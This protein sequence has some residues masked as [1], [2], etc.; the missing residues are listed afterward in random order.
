MRLGGRNDLTIAQRETVQTIWANWS[1]RRA[2]AAMD[3]GNLRRAVEILEAA[4]QAFPDN[5]A[6][7]KAVAGGYARVGRAKESLALYRAIPMQDASSGDFQGAIGAALQA[8]D[9]NQA[10]LWLRQALDRFATDP[11]ILA[12]AA[13]YEQARLSTASPTTP[14][15][16]TRTRSRIAP[17]QPQTCITCLTPTTSPSLRQRSSRRSPPTDPIP[18]TVQPQ[19][20]LSIRKCSR[21][22]RRSQR[23]SQLPRQQELT[24]LRPTRTRIQ[25]PPIPIQPSG[26]S[27]HPCRPTR[28]SSTSKAQLA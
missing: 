7:R 16:P 5:L 19:S 21:K 15:I 17:S 23:R 6:V 9:K 10:E 13:R 25:T 12:L 1:V 20:S 8:N 11:A 14:S 22:C 26:R 4:S 28:S 27:L 24:P 2:A 3:N 18:T